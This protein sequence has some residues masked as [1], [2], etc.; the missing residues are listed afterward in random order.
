[1]SG[2]VAFTQVRYKLADDDGPFKYIRLEPHETQVKFPEVE[3]SKNYIIE[4]RNVGPTGLTSRWVDLLQQVPQA[5]NP[6]APSSL[7]GTSLVNGI[8]LKWAMPKG[9]PASTVYEVQR[10]PNVNG[11]PGAFV[12][13]GTTSAREYIDPLTVN[14]VYWYRVN[15]K[16]RFE[17]PSDT[18][19]NT[20][21]VDLL[22]EAELEAKIDAALEEA[23]NK[24]AASDGAVDTFWQ[25]T[26][27]PIGDG[28][29]EAKVGDIWFDT[30]NNDKVYR[31]KDGAWVESPKDALAEA[32]KAA[33]NAQ[34]TADGKVKLYVGLNPPSP[35]PFQLNDL[36]FNQRTNTL[37]RWTGSAWDEKVAD[38]TLDQIAGRGINLMDDDWCVLDDV[39]GSPLYDNPPDSV[40]IESIQFTSAVKM[41]PQAKGCM[42][43]TVNDPT[44][45]VSQSWMYFGRTATDYNLPVEGGKKYIF[46]AYVRSDHSLAKFGLRLKTADGVLRNIVDVTLGANQQTVR[47]SGV[48]DLSNVNVNGAIALI[49]FNR[50]GA[51]APFNVWID[52]LMVEE[53]IGNLATP[54]VW[55]HG[56][57][58][59]L[60]LEALFEAQSARAIADG[61]I[62]I[63]RQASPPVIGGTGAG[64]GDYWQDSDDGRWYYCTGSSWVET[65]DSRLPQVVV[66]LQNTNLTVSKKTRLFYQEGTPT[67]TAN[68]DMWYQPSSGITRYWNGTGWSLLADYAPDSADMLV[69]NPE[70]SQNLTHWT[71]GGGWY[72]EASTNA[73]FQGTGAVRPANGGGRPDGPLVSTKS[74]SVKP[75]ERV[76]VTAKIRN[77]N[78]AA[79]GM[80]HVGLAFYDGTGAYV[81]ERLIGWDEGL[82]IASSPWRQCSRKLTVVNRAATARVLFRPANHTVGYWCVDGVRA[83]HVDDTTEAP[84]SGENMIP[85]GNFGL[86]TGNWPVDTRQVVLGEMLTDGWQV[87]HMGGS[88][89]VMH[90]GL[91]LN[92]SSTRQLFIGDVGSVI[93]PGDSW[94]YATTSQSFSVKP[95]EKYVLDYSG[96]ADRGNSPPPGVTPW[97]HMGL[98]CYNRDGVR[99]AFVGLS[100]SNRTGGFGGQMTVTIPSGTAEVRGMVGYRLNNSNSGNTSIPWAV[101]H[102]RF[103]EIKVRRQASLDE[104]VVTD[105]NNYG[106]THNDDLYVWGGWRRMG[107]RVRGS[108]HLLGGAR[109]IRAAQ[110]MGFNAVRNTNSLTA[111]S[112]GVVNVNAH[113]VNLGGEV[114]TY[115][116]VANAITGLTV[117]TT[118]VIYT[119]DPYMDGGTRTYYAQTTVLSAAQA[120]EGAI[121]VG[122]IT[123]PSSGSSGGGGGGGGDPGDWCVDAEMVLPDG[124]KAADIKAGDLVPCWN[125]DAANPEVEWVE[126][127]SN[128][129]VTDQP[130]TLIETLDGAMVIASNSTPMTL[131]DGRTVRMPE[132]FGED[133]LVLRKGQTPYWSEVVRCVPLGQ[134]TV[135]KIKVRQR[136]YFAGVI[137][138]L[139]IATHN[140][141]QKP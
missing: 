114:V 132:M 116:A 138:D 117:G 93:A 57:A 131:R 119:I 72:A 63:Y 80:M 52:R 134:R 95:G 65:P 70:F 67:A 84:V 47:I 81:D 9:T 126:V 28:A 41:L 64:F 103:K 75:G 39:Q 100:D 135:A 18:Y 6:A 10:A 73:A 60:S 83:S 49:Y 66:D 97:I 23:I 51:V 139:T 94:V 31:C 36:W 107:L 56:A 127:E 14:G 1:M 115:N 96:Q 44:G 78:N 34:S 109:N 59:N 27:P 7:Q 43:F 33:V 90:A 74:I 92:N 61:K 30:D 128:T 137:T 62:D 29:N 37:L 88:S 140:P 76:F 55:S 136:C 104:Q 8:H 46:S 25:P 26:A 16:N 4:A 12:E 20:I 113:T 105:G 42:R 125:E 98:Y 122:N 87:G 53:Q 89:N 120:G 40:T 38:I 124:R 35:G 102:I 71:N 22:T 19:S 11:A 79:N 91:D 118:Y 108:R 77:L 54:S 48:M 85:N 32:I 121:H 69:L 58:T 133:A 13:V 99:F 24:V 21:S 112:A 2:P 68:G 111:T 45:A 3:R 15:A 82:Q 50:H 129:L 141:T 86:N 17:D 101:N 110:V 106:R 5:A 130:S 123:I